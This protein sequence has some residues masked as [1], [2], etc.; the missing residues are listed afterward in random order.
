MI[1]D[2]HKDE[3]TTINVT[4]EDYKGINAY[5]KKDFGGGKKF[6]VKILDGKISH[7]LQMNSHLNLV[8]DIFIK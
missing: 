7:K 5:L 8:K 3:V 1:I 2:K 6:S 4:T